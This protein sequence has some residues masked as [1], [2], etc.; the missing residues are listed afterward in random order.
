MSDNPVGVRL[1]WTVSRDSSNPNVQGIARGKG[2]EIQLTKENRE[3]IINMINGT[4]NSTDSPIKI[5]AAFPKFLRISNT[6]KAEIAFALNQG[7]LENLLLLE[8]TFV[9]HL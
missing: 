3:N 9:T 6:G 1:T 2:D 8:N 7:E 4:S 5:I